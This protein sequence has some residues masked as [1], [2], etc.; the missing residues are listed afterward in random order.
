MTGRIGLQLNGYEVTVEHFP[1]RKKPCLAVR[2][3]GDPA[4]YKVASFNS[5]ETADWFL[6]QMTR[7]F[8]SEKEEPCHE[9]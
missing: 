7:M 1:E 4:M 6:T 8:S 5:E 9:S 3:P 2:I